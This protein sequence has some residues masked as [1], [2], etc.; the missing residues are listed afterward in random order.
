MIT[1]VVDT[2]TL[3]SGLVRRNPASPVVAVVDGWRARRF[4]L[5]I[6]E[7]ILAELT[8]AL[9]DPYF[10]RHLTPQQT[11]RFLALL[12]RRAT[13]VPITV[14]VK[15]VATHPEDD[16][17]LA[18]AVSAKAD[19]LVSGDRQLQARASYQ[20]V[21]IVSARGFVPILDRS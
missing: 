20:D 5:A 6:S 12:R 14:E 3:A 13:L 2:N 9:A 15:G 18:T 21:T 1:V 11:Q 16:L 10:Q 7:H 8:R 4:R 17:V 19:Y